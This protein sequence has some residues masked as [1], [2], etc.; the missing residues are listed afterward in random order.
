M[1][2]MVPLTILTRDPFSVPILGSLLSFQGFYIHSPTR[3]N[4][5]PLG[6]YLVD[7]RFH[8]IHHSMEAGHFDKNFGVFTT[9]WDS[10][11]GTA[12]FPAPGE[13]PQTGVADFPEPTTLRDF[14]L[15]PFTWRKDT[16]PVL[17]DAPAAETA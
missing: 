1:L 14:L 13:W 12:Y 7:N 4:F 11:F 17:A 15:S 2:Y 3:I 9:L 5:G 10:L 16:A 8:R 6:R